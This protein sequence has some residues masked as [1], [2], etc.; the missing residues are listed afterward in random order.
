MQKG[1]GCNERAI[2]KTMTRTAVK[3]ETLSY[4]PHEYFMNTTRFNYNWLD[5][6]HRQQTQ[7]NAPFAFLLRRYSTIV[8]QW[9]KVEAGSEGRKQGVRQGTRQGKTTGKGRGDNKENKEKGEGILGFCSFS[10]QRMTEKRKQW[11]ER[12]C[13]QRTGEKGGGTRTLRTGQHPKDQMTIGNTHT[14]LRAKKTQVPFTN[15]T[16]ITLPDHYGFVI[17]IF[18]SKSATT[19]HWSSSTRNGIDSNKMSKKNHRCVW[20]PRRNRK[21]AG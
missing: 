19:T 6:N 3:S 7:Q 14:L 4:I 15:T 11:L 8:G 5:Y 2:W 9:K 13:C 21:R 12:L 10:V 20:C 16:P 18:H 1:N 17:P